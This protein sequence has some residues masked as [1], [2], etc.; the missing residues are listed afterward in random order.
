MNTQKNQRKTHILETESDYD[1]DQDYP[2]MESDSQATSKISVSD[3]N[4]GIFTPS[5]V[6][7][8]SQSPLN[9]N[10]QTTQD[11][12]KSGR[13]NTAQLK[14]KKNRSIELP[15]ARITAYRTGICT[16]MRL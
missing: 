15:G 11:F 1:L 9:L 4:E 2:E 8:E 7:M 10:R 3:K 12:Y 13:S 5:S 6:G 14:F 16:R